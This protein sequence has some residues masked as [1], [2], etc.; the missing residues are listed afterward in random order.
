MSKR[1]WKPGVYSWECG[2][3]VYPSSVFPCGIPQDCGETGTA[4]FDL[5][6][7]GDCPEAECTRCGSELSGTY[8]HF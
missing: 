3:D 8:D 1:D 6:D 5:E 7:G 4:E 2:A